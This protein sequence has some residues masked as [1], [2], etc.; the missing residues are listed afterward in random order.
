MTINTSSRIPKH[1]QTA[2]L[3]KRR[4]EKGDYSPGSNFP[5][6]RMLGAELGVSSNVV[7]RAV[8]ILEKEGVVESQHGVGVRV[9]ESGGTRRT[10]LTFGLVYPYHPNTPF[11][12]TI[13]TMAE[14]AIDLQ[15]NHCIIKSSGG[16]PLDE[17]ETIEKFLESG[18]EGLM[19]WP[20]P[21]EENVEF[22]RKI[23]ERTSIV[24]IDRTFDQLPIPGIALDWTGVG[25]DI[26]QYLA[27]QGHRRVLI[28]EDP[29]SISSFR[30]MYSSMRETVTA[31]SGRDRFSFVEFEAGRFYELYPRDPRAAVMQYQVRLGQLLGNDAFEAFFSPYD[32]QIDRVYA[33]T[34]LR[35][36]F[37]MREIVSMTNTRPTPRSLEFYSLGLREWISDFETVLRKATEILHEIIFL[38][39]RIQHQIRIRFTSIV[40]TSDVVT[41]G[42]KNE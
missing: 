38:K 15:N 4:I 39:S 10:P 22:F 3:L 20:C 26:I 31:I 14:E 27:Q 34:S 25:R 9:L 21:G 40:R 32:E 41:G 13:H 7:Q 17:R 18:V 23:A 1:V 35:R 19:I 33:C 16:N 42:L 24:F 29:I 6:V 28:L 36:E 5:P 2:V 11:A 8:Q 12:G 30:Q 37:P